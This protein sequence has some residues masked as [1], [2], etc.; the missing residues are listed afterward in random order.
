MLNVS[1]GCTNLDTYGISC[2]KCG[3]CGRKFTSHGVDDSEVINK[4]VKEY[5]KF[6]DTEMYKDISLIFDGDK[7]IIDKEN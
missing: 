7:I 3:K 1:V 2:I 5:N 6:L 4:K